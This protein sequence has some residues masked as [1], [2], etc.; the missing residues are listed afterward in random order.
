VTAILI[1][2]LLDR[3][4]RHKAGLIASLL[5]IITLPTLKGQWITA[6]SLALPL[7]LAS[8]ITHRS[9]LSGMFVAF[10]GLFY[11]YAVL[12]VPAVFIVQYFREQNNR[13]RWSIEYGFSGLV[14]LVSV[15]LIMAIIWTSESALAGFNWSY[16]INLGV[17]SPPAVTS[18]PRPDSYIAAS[19]LLSKPLQW[20][21]VGFYT[22]QVWF[23][24]IVPVSMGIYY[25]FTNKFKNRLVLH[26]SVM[27]LF[28]W[29]PFLIRSYRDYSLLSHVFICGIAGIG[30]DLWFKD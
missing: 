12:A 6:S 29:M 19:W 5:F 3:Y 8:L 26:F 21:G 10:G 17:T 24:L 18:I 13:L 22:F 25:T 27:V 16:G 7:I 1:W 15:F 14:T 2:K 9:Y 28:L 11:Q 30:L 23:S 20:A 4:D